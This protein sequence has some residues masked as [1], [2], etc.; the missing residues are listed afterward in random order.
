MAQVN[1]MNWIVQGRERVLE[2]AFRDAFDALVA[3][4]YL[5]CLK[6]FQPIEPPLFYKQQTCINIP[7]RLDSFR[8]FCTFWWLRVTASLRHGFSTCDAPDM[9]FRLGFQ[10][11]VIVCIASSMSQRLEGQLRSG[12]LWDRRNAVATLAQNT[13]WLKI[14]ISTSGHMLCK[15]Q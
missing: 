7:V 14:G 9:G 4:C 5:H 11:G 2:F 15:W 6:K 10:R 3:W 1:R 12:W 13:R 8:R